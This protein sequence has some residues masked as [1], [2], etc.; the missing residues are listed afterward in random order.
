[1]R[2]VGPNAYFVRMRF[3]AP[4][5]VVAAL[6]VSF[7][8]PASAVTG[9]DADDAHPFVAALIPQGAS[10]PTCSGV[11]TDVGGG[12]RVVITDAHCVRATRGSTVN[13]FFGTRWSSSARTIR[14]HSYRHPSYDSRTHRNDVAV[15]VLD[16]DPHTTPASLARSGTATRTS[17][18]DVVGY[19]T[20]HTGQRRH[21][22]ERVTSWSSWRLYLRPESGNSCDGDSGAPDLVP[23]TRQV[24]AL[25]DMGTCSRDEDTRLDTGSARDFVTSRH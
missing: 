25:T 21:A 8:T 18:V 22:T 19:G 6:C 12:R 14:G 24:V 9:G 15:V 17:R 7:A 13:V 5:V 20:P 4:L 1:M 2:A 11:W 10:H 23:G 3:A 16:R